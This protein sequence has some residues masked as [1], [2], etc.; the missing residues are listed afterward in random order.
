MEV[1]STN[2]GER[3]KLIYKKRPVETGIFK[4]PVPSVNLGITDVINDNV[5]DRKYHGGEKKACY[6]YSADHYAYW[7]KK[8]PHLPWN[9]GFFGENITVS[10]LDETQ[11]QIG[12]QYAIGDAIIEITTPREP[13]F[14]LGL[15]FNT[16]KIIRDFIAVHFCGSYAKV[17]KEGEVK[18]GDVMKLIFKRDSLTIAEKF[19]EIYRK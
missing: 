14:K 2:I 1:V 18:K 13:C 12:N 5:V 9:W 7:K 10:G 19:K 6:L 8:Y 3:K 4:Y 15:R 11:L 17:I 16:Q